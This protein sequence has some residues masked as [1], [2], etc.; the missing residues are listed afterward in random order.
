LISLIRTSRFLKL[1]DAYGACNLTYPE[2][3]TVK[4]SGTTESVEY[5]GG[6][7]TAPEPD[8]LAAVVRMMQRLASRMSHFCPANRLVD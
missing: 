5:R 2:A 3:I 7:E 4:T 6:T 1:Q 8:V